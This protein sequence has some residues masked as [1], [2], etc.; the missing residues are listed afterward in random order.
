[1]GNLSLC[2]IKCE[3]QKDETIYLHNLKDNIVIEKG[4]KELL[5]ITPEYYFIAF[6]LCKD[7]LK[8]NLYLICINKINDIDLYLA[9]KKDDDKMKP[10]KLVKKDSSIM[11]Y[12]SLY[13]DNSTILTL[14]TLNKYE[15]YG[16]RLPPLTK[17]NNSV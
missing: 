2:S 9:F 5:R 8:T 17:E 7:N 14:Y 15:S 11:I 10:Y 16:V 1:M 12:S 6:N 3:E 4:F 13:F